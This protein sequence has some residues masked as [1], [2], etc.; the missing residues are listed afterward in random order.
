MTTPRGRG[1]APRR[2]AVPSG[3]CRECGR[4]IKMLTNGTVGYHPVSRPIGGGAPTCEGSYTHPQ[5]IAA[6]ANGGPGRG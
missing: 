2:R 6:L 1:T 4:S 5:D 3:L